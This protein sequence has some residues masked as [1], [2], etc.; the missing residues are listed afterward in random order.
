MNSQPSSAS[1]T[2]TL[3]ANRLRPIRGSAAEAARWASIGAG[4]LLLVGVG[5]LVHASFKPLPGIDETVSV[6][7]PEAVLVPTRDN[8]IESR[9][10]MLARVNARNSY[11]L[12]PE[13]WEQQT[14]PGVL[15]AAEGGA[16]EDGTAGGADGAAGPEGGGVAQAAAGPGTPGSPSGGP[17]TA[18]D[19]IE[20]VE[21][22]P[23]NIAG[24]L[25][26]ITLLG[27][28]AAGDTA[29]IIIENRNDMENGRP[30]RRNLR[31][32]DTFAGG[33]WS[34]TAVDP[35]GWRTILTHQGVNTELRLFDR[36]STPVARAEPAARRAPGPTT[37]R[38]E[39]ST[40]DAVRAELL[41]Q[42]LPVGEIEELMRLALDGLDLEAVAVPEG[43]QAG[44]EP[45]AAEPAQSQPAAAREQEQGSQN[46]GMQMI[47]KMLSG[48]PFGEEPQRAQ[49]PEEPEEDSP[50]PQ[51]DG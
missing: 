24:P 2:R 29:S 16:N 51:G 39:R 49:E 3:P 26:K 27:V 50:E 37:F 33:E 44:A 7:V 40:P 5:F 13:S 4:G 17:L 47:L 14:G 22:P 30:E 20:V 9:E 8:S 34:V 10:R 45:A 19:L 25:K 32:G 28:Y 31:V 23:P 35:Q 11:T 36:V 21:E 1:S 18:Y 38:L 12:Y 42:E 6:A 15:T 43:A 41:E 48:N 46:A